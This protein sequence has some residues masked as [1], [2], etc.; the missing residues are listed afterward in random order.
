MGGALRARKKISRWQL[1]RNLQNERMR[2]PRISKE[3]KR[4]HEN[5]E[6]KTERESCFGESREQKRRLEAAGGVGVG[7]GLLL[8]HNE[9]HVN[10]KGTFISRAHVYVRNEGA[11]E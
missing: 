1:A 5:D 11:D 10:V 2:E 8:Q 7:G 3:N 6:T 9:K 4:I